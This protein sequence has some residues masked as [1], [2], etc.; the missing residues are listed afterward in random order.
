MLIYTIIEKTKEGKLQGVKSFITK[1][2][3]TEHLIY[4]AREFPKD[5]FEVIT[6]FASEIVDSKDIEDDRV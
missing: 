6:S 1:E 2:E 3:L 4:L 5:S